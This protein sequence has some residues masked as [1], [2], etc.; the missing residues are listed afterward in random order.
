M[1][2]VNQW[3][4]EHFRT[5]VMDCLNRPNQYL[6][7]THQHFYITWSLSEPLKCLQIYLLHSNV[8]R[9]EVKC[10]QK[11]EVRY[12]GCQICN[13][14]I[15]ARRF[16]AITVKDELSE[17]ADRRSCHQN[18]KYWYQLLIN[19]NKIKIGHNSPEGEL[20]STDTVLIWRKWNPYFDLLWNRDC[21]LMAV[22]HSGDSISSIMTET[23]FCR[24]MSTS[25]NWVNTVVVVTGVVQ[26]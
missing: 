3:L 14:N 23:A 12:N 22:L 4:E 15:R 1:E 6:E 18:A 25:F 20:L 19:C 13:N 9:K 2:A 8:D 17:E 7:H 24:E 10:Y 16:S 11:L 26:R 5:G 21:A